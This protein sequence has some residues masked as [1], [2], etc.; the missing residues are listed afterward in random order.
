MKIKE[1]LSKTQVLHLKNLKNLKNL[2]DLKNPGLDLSLPGGWLPG[3]LSLRLSACQPA[4][5]SV[6]GRT[7]IFHWR[8]PYG[9]Q[10]PSHIEEQTEGHIDIGIGI[11]AL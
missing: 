9:K 6:C 1:N 8:L 10:T 11:T 2:K 7:W 4:A 5:Q 3:W